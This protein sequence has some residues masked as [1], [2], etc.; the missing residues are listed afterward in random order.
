[1]SKK[2]VI[3]V[4]GK[5]GTG[6]TTLATLLLKWL[7]DNTREVVLVVD[8]DS[9]TNLP[10]VLGVRLERTV[11]QISKEM[12]DQIEMGTLPPT[13]PKRNLLEA[14][15]FQTLVEENLFD[16]LAMGR[17]EGEGCYCFVNNI[18]T[19]ILDTLTRNYSRARAILK[20]SSSDIGMDYGGSIPADEGVMEFNMTGKPILGLPETS[21]A[22]IAVNRIAKKIGLNEMR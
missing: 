22:Y 2:L 9:A 1:M 15:V 18:L 12:K 7:I 10:H 17:S 20:K 6:K 16:L 3:S 11:G 8:A 4:S 13:V 19:R 21:P 5:G 14:W